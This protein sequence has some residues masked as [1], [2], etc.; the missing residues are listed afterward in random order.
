MMHALEV[1]SH[2]QPIRK[3]AQRLRWFF[4]SFDEQV[5]RVSAKTGVTYSVDRTVLAEAF[6]DWLKSFNAQKPEASKDNL[7][8]VGFAAAL[9]L[10]TLI[11]KKPLKVSTQPDTADDTQPGYFWPEG[12]LYV[13][14]CLKVR[15]MVIER[16]FD[17]QQQ[18]NEMLGDIRTWWSFKENVE[19]DP[20]LAIAFLDLFANEEPNW[21]TPGLFRSRALD[22]LP[23]TSRQKEL[24]HPIA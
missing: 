19:E 4:Q 5:A 6:A 3:S 1:A 14:Y 15:G 23:R 16:D 7:A 21:K 24:I 8:Y 10:R 20:S 13:T 9:M 11:I 22:E 12:Y 2:G 17:G 18:A